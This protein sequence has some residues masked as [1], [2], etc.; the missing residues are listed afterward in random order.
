MD[1]LYPK[2]LCIISISPI[3]KEKSLAYEF[4]LMSVC[5]PLKSESVDFSENLVFTKLC[6]N[7][8]LLD[9]LVP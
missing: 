2:Y 8:M 3:L 7:V 5:P 9:N 1:F 4:S 6:M